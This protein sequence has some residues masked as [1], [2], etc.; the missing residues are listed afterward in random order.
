MEKLGMVG[1]VLNF[2]T[3][4]LVQVDLLQGQPSLQSEF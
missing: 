2:S 4:D 1:H 3:Q